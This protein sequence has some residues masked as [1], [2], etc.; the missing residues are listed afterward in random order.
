[1]NLFNKKRNKDEYLK[2]NNGK[3]VS[4]GKKD[5]IPKDYRQIEYEKELKDGFFNE[6]DLMA[7]YQTNTD[8]DINQNDDNE[9]KKKNKISSLLI[10]IGMFII[11]ISILFLGFK[12]FINYKNNLNNTLNEVEQNVVNN[13]K[14]NNKANEDSD[15]PKDDNE[16]A[17]KDNNKIPTESTNEMSLTNLSDLLSQ[18]DNINENIVKAY[19][20]TKSDIINYTDRVNGINAT[21]QSL[22]DRKNRIIKNK[23]AVQDMTTTFDTLN[24]VEVQNSLLRRYD[25]LSTCIDK[26]LLDMSKSRVIDIL[27]STINDEN[28]SAMKQE[29]IIRNSLN[30]NNVEYTEKDGKFTIK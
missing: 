3:I 2:Y 19:E 9:P 10:K 5:S 23:Q 27:N 14:D 6:D 8:I 28:T 1:M 29:E 30:N 16:E 11:I 13:S 20:A 17:P 21:T 22:R 15:K 7:R 18:V 12:A 25:T 26:L 24:L 4:V